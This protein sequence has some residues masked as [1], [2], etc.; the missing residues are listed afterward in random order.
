MASLP[1][2]ASASSVARS[3]LAITWWSACLGLPAGWLALPVTVVLAVAFAA[4]DLAAALHWHPLVPRPRARC[5]EPLPRPARRLAVARLA[6]AGVVA[7]I[8]LISGTAAWLAAI[9]ILYA[10]SNGILREHFP[11]SYGGPSYVWVVFRA[12]V[13]QAVGDERSHQVARQ[14]RPRLW[15]AAAVAV[16]GAALAVPAMGD[17]RS[18]FATL[19]VKW[20]VDEFRRPLPPRVGHP[21]EESEETSTTTTEAPSSGGRQTDP[22]TAELLTDICG[23]DVLPA[24]PTGAERLRTRLEARWHELGGVVAGCPTGETV[25]PD[26]G[27]VVVFL[28]GGESDPAAIIAS[29]NSTRATFVREDRIDIARKFLN[30]GVL[31][32]VDELEKTRSVNY[33][34]FK[35]TRG[36]TLSVNSFG[37]GRTDLTT[38]QSAAVI[39][40]V[41][42][43][44]GTIESLSSTRRHSATELNLVIDLHGKSVRV[45]LVDDGRVT[46]KGGPASVVGISSPPDAR[47][48]EQQ[49]ADVASRS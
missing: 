5:G 39:Q 10:V 15:I 27:A 37:F 14:L 20:V 36:C 43:I 33:Q 31:V 30:A 45:R 26:S 4:R 8:A 6:T 47:C 22:K 24:L 41:A 7:L 9:P 49:A 35:L 13:R 21:G 29:P 1:S 34:L 25:V 18:Q 19:G 46:I 2:S 48:P 17:T 42:T 23:S 28:H 12:M 38:A 32:G 3:V 11:D 16:L 44:G 40:A